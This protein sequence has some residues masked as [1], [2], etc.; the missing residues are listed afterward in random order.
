MALSQARLPP[1]QP[2]YF[3]CHARSTFAPTALAP[4]NVSSGDTM[5]YRIDVSKTGGSISSRTVMR[6]PLPAGVS[7]VGPITVT[8]IAGVVQTTAT[9][10]ISNTVVWQGALDP[11]AHVRVSF[12]VRVNHCIGADRSVTNVANAR[13]DDGN[14][15]S[16][17]AV[18]GVNCVR[19]PN[20]DVRKDVFVHDGGAP[21]PGPEKHV[22]VGAAGL[23]K[24]MVPLIRR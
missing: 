14:I 20:V 18:V 1:A 13:D 10:F 22:T 6:D 16:D 9:H 19:E 5:I 3:A 23:Y 17:S 21:S 7:Y 12:Q 2:V 11:S 4:A 24:V 8:T 15:V